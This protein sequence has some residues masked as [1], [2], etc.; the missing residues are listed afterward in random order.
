MFK[1]HNFNIGL[2]DNLVDVNEFL[3]ILRGKLNNLQCLYCEKTFTSATVLRKHMRKKKHFKISPHNH[4]YDRFYVINYIETGKSW[5]EIESEKYDS[6]QDKQ[7]NSWEDWKEEEGDVMAETKSL[8]DEKRFRTAEECVNY[9]RDEYG[10][11]LPK[12]EADLEMGFYGIVALIN[13]IR[14]HVKESRCFGCKG[15]FE[16]A[17]ELSTHFKQAKASCLVDGVSE[18]KDEELKDPQYLTPVIESDP[19]L[20]MMVDDEGSDANKEAEETQRIV[21]ENMKRLREM[22]EPT[23]PVGIVSALGRK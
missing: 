3:D 11:N 21:S 14:K 1:E 23:I 19:L 22:A 7:D 12:V 20:M 2:P 4:L 5:E 15:Q 13:Y 18:A 16:G 9:M 6:D 10:F 8:F 17:E